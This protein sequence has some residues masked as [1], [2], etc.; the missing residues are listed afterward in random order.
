MT[1]QPQ[2]S[3]RELQEK[4]ID[5]LVNYWH[6]SD[7]SFL[8]SM[9]VDINKLPSREAL[10]VSLLGQ[11]KTPIELKSSYC[12]I[13]LL[14]NKA[15]GH[16]NTNPTQFGEEAYMHLHLWN[17]E[18]RTKGLGTKFVIMSLSHF[19]EKLKLKRL[20]SEPYALN[21]APNKTLKKLGFSLVKEHT[22]IPGP[23]CFKQPIKRWEMTNHKF[24]MNTF[25]PN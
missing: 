25:Y 24:K 12:I 15:I 14:D 21:P 16:S 4:D 22:T 11:I 19:F 2:L 8:K 23:I 1:N 17:A 10:R 5:S 20:F 6:E 18:T 3:I 7:S 13:W 9:G